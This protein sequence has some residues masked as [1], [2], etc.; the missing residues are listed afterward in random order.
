MNV[1]VE[2]HRSW[3]PYYANPKEPKPD[4]PLKYDFI[5]YGKQADVISMAVQG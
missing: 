5:K 1:T 2:L 4:D 3:R